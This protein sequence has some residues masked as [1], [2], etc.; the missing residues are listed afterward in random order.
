MCV[1]VSVYLCICVS[2]SVCLC[3]TSY[4]T[5]WEG[6]NS[7]ICLKFGTHKAWVNPWGCLFQFLKICVFRLYLGQ[8]LPLILNKI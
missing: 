8:D 7:Q 6:I 4:E 5:L 3:P 2:V 1:C